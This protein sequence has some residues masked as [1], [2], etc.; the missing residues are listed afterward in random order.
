[1]QE[2]VCGSLAVLHQSIKTYGKMVAI[3]VGIKSFAIEMPVGCEKGP[4]NSPV[5]LI[6]G[7]C[8]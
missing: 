2:F 8:T 6:K 4:L 1:M 3:Q 7:K 5:F